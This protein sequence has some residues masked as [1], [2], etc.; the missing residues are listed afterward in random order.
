M[1]TVD[2]R[3]MIIPKTDYVIGY[4]GDNA[5]ETRLF[6]LNRYYNNIDLS[7][8]DFKLDIKSGGAN[9][10]DLDKETHSDKVIL[11]WSIQDKHLTSKGIAHIQLRGFD[12]FDQV[13][14]STIE[15]VMINK[16]INATDAFPDPLPT[17]F[18]EMEARI[19]AAKNA[20]ID[21]AASAKESENKMNEL[22]KITA[23]QPDWGIW[24][25][26]V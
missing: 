22:I 7:L 17:E 24:L 10:I 11:T 14:H 9:V 15:Y 4:Q 19:T 2:G 13:W 20:A 12:A 3:K 26:E 21:A 1:I 18:A 8:L 23:T 5:V 6:E 16:S 25:E